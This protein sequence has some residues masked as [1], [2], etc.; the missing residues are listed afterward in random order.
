MA[1]T[2]QPQCLQQ[3]STVGANQQPTPLVSKTIFFLR[4]KKNSTSGLPMPSRT[5]QI[6]QLLWCFQIQLMSF[7]TL[8][9]SSATMWMLKYKVK[10][11]VVRRL[12]WK[13]WMSWT[14]TELKC[15]IHTHNIV[16]HCDCN[17]T[18]S[19]R[20]YIKS[21]HH[22]FVLPG[23]MDYFFP[24][25]NWICAVTSQKNKNILQTTVTNHTQH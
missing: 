11:K 6:F 13:G 23:F 22:W 8:V 5:A 20:L 9:K 24:R 19:H 7:S 4:H 15:E 25:P 18:H 14:T 21:T 12:K 16:C 3:H 2:E 1:E 17:V 10:H